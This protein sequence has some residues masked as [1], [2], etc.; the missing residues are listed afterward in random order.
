MSAK[1]PSPKCR[2]VLLDVSR[3]L[4]GEL[5]PSRRRRVEAHIDS[6]RCCGTMAA[7][8]RAVIAACRAAG[9][10]PAPR[11]VMARASTRIRKLLDE[12]QR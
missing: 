4:D 8:L 12:G 3:Y 11:A 9:R 10:T 2:A 1:R 6:C 5:S 7:R